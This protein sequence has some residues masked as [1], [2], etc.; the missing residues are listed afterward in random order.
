MKLFHRIQDTE[1]AYG[2]LILKWLK[3]TQRDYEKKLKR[4]ENDNEE[5]KRALQI[6]RKGEVSKADNGD[7]PTPNVER[8][9]NPSVDGKFTEE[10]DSAGDLSTTIE[11]N[12]GEAGIEDYTSA[13]DELCEANGEYPR[14]TTSV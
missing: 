1:R 13:R 2:A 12:E 9:L 6:L 11:H 5:S 4:L 8:I 14:G 3:G 10:A 7:P